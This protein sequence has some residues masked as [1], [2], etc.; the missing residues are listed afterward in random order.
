MPKHKLNQQKLAFCVNFFNFNLF[1]ANQ[2]S[3]SADTDSQ[4]AAKHEHNEEP[5][6]LAG[7]NKFG[8]FWFDEM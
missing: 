6:A 8:H 7:I 5:F 1:A 4:H 3:H 2:D